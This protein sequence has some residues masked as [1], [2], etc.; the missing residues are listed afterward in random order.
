MHIITSL[1]LAFPIIIIHCTSRFSTVFLENMVYFWYY[2]LIRK[3]LGFNFLSLGEGYTSDCQ[4][5]PAGRWWS[6]SIVNTIAKYPKKKNVMQSW[7]SSRGI[8]LGPIRASASSEATIW[9]ETPRQWRFGWCLRNLHRPPR[10]L[11]WMCNY[12]VQEKSDG[13]QCRDFVIFIASG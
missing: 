8:T 9:N 5:V 13:S 2:F 1:L 7:W 4:F 12:R 6:N 11:P 10:A 3:F